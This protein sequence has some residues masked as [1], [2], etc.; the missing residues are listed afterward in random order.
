[1]QQAS[2]Q[3][4][5][6]VRAFN[7]FYTGRIGA[8]SASFLDSR[9]SLTEVRVLY[10]LAHNP[11]TAASELEADLGLDAGY[12]SRMLKRFADQGL[13]SQEPDP[14]DRRRRRL[15]LTEHGRA[16]F[17]PLERRQRDLVAAML[18]AL[19]P[20]ANAHLI[21]A[22]STVRNLLDEQ[23][24]A[25]PIGLR[26]HGPG[27]MGW[28]V[29]RHGEIYGREYGWDA[30]F[31]AL[32][33]R[34]CADF[35][36]HLDPERERC[37]IAERYGERLGSIMLV[38]HPERPDT[39]KLRLLLVAP[40]ARGLGVGS[41]LVRACVGFAAEAGYRRVTL[42]TNDVL[43]SARRIYEAAGFALVHSE[44]HRSFGC[45][46]VGQTFE[47]ELTSTVQAG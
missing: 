44:P 41:S 33:A 34:I 39:A 12:L 9:F 40:W 26:P 4:I 7:R 46:L 17:A 14:V 19:P 43:T 27:D 25:A 23:L 15:A 42:W 28:I 20:G 22:M 6:A 38:R 30:S 21:E 10:E 36:D 47:L 8:L 45:D 31:E 2:D 32:V 3:D 37:W 5:A 18:A 13:I 24:A 1:M 11:G 35:I 29:Q 16:V